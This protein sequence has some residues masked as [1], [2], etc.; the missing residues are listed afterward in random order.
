GDRGRPG[1]D[2][3]DLPQSADHL[4]RGLQYP[5]RLMN[6]LTHVYLIALLPLVASAI[7][8]FFGEEGPES[9]LPYFSTAVM[10]WCLIHSVILFFIAAPG[11]FALPYSA[12]WDWFQVGDYAFRLGVLI[13]GPA[14]VMLVV[15]TLVGFL[16][17]LYSIGYMHGDKRFKRFYAYLSFFTA[18]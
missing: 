5:E 10:G 17:Q 6:L 1:A 14:V 3:G 13:D 15:V 2:L 9:K 11:S 7:V 8:L 12:Q 18:S 16:V 4:R